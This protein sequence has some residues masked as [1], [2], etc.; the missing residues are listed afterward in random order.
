MPRLAV[1]FAIVGVAA[2]WLSAG[3]LANPLIGVTIEPNQG[4]AAVC[5]G[6][7]AA[8]VGAILTRR[9][10]P[11][12]LSGLPERAGGTLVI[13]VLLGGVVAEE[14]GCLLYTSPSPRDS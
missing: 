5:A 3:L 12:T 11:I 1:P 10:R 14:H 7:I 4:L 9:C 8:I 2:G 13:T 6:L